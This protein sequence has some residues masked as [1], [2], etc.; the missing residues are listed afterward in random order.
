VDEDDEHASL[1]RSRSPQI[2]AGELREL[3][4]SHSGRDRTPMSLMIVGSPMSR[5]RGP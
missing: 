3:A 1:F 4:S 2:G 5:Q